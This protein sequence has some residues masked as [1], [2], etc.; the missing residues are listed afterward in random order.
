LKSRT[1]LKGQVDILRQP[2][3]TIAQHLLENYARLDDDALVL[4]ARFP[5]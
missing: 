2:A 4:V 1:S 5:I 3:I